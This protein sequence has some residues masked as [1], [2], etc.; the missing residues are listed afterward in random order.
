MA[1]AILP[2]TLHNGYHSGDL[3]LISSNCGISFLAGNNY[4]SD[5]KS[6][7]PPGENP[8][9]IRDPE[10]ARQVA[11]RIAG[12]S[13]SPAEVSSFY[14]NQGLH[15]LE[16]SPKT[17]VGLIAKRAIMAANGY[18][19][20]TERPFYETTT[21]SWLLSILTW[22]R[23]ISFPMGIL[24]PIF[25][26]GLIATFGSW[27]KLVLFYSFLLSTAAWPL[28]FYVNVETRAY[29]AIGIIVFASTGI[30]KIIKY[31]REKQLPG[32][33][34]ALVVAV[35]FLFVSNYDLIEIK[36]QPELPYLQRGIAYW[37][38]G[39]YD[40]A[41]EEFLEGLE[42]NPDSPLLLNNLAN[43][44]YKKR[45]YKEAEKKYRRA[46]MLQ[47][48]YLDA[49]K[50]LVRLYER[51][52]RED[53]LY[54]AY[55]EFLEYFPNSEWGLFRMGE[56]FVEQLQDDSALVIYEKLVALDPENPDARFALA[57]LYIKKGR[58]DEARVIY[59]DMMQVYPDDLRIHLNLGL[60]YVHLG[61]NLQ[62]EDEF[63]Y[64][65]SEDS[66]N[67]FALYNMARLLESRGDSGVATSLFLKILAVDPD[68]Y[69]NSEEIYD[70]LIA[71]SG[72][73]QQ[74]DSTSN[75]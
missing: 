27:R 39:N 24:I 74:R 8:E 71:G 32:F 43:V 49:R 26:V 25:I 21:S 73:Y 20:Q 19:I 12:K 62:A 56:Y 69:E 61:K 29:L 1:I 52:E 30:V 7:I 58:A 46:L 14:L 38:E 16:D 63:T 75:R 15:L 59:E 36:G 42:H 54:H 13:L 18:E 68:F 70:S 11:E 57:N 48:D 28:L 10:V 44:Y 35:V 3:I 53:M 37:D 41:Q 47:P 50:N 40:A 9:I 22:D 51:W 67:T 45:I 2:V 72:R 17:A 31:A 23:V 55:S 33:S 60:A 65:L 6:A 66:T 64:V 4:N 5:G 34:G